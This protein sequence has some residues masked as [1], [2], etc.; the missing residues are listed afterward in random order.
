MADDFCQ[1]MDLP[2]AWCAHCRNPH[3]LT[4]DERARELR[5]AEP[6]VFHTQPRREDTDERV[7][8]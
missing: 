8:A 7:A 6:V 3:Q 1:V 2:T 4:D 5:R